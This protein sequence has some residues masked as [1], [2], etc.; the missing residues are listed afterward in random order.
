MKFEFAVEI[1]RQTGFSEIIIENS[2]TQGGRSDISFRYMNEKYQVEMKTANTSWR[3]NGVETLTR[4]ITMNIDGIIDD[5][6]VLKSKCPPDHGLAVFTLFPIPQQLLRYYPDK[7]DSHLH[8]IE[9]EAELEEAS[10]KRAMNLIPITEDY[11]VGVF[12]I[13]I[14]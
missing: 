4:P 14:V 7:L 12:V 5:I 3:V 6:G 10:L 8:R 1:R 9:R 2:Y 11:G 13:H